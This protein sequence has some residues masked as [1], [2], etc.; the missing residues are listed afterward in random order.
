MKRPS[1]YAVSPASSNPARQLTTPSADERSLGYHT[2]A[3]LRSA[4]RCEPTLKTVL[5]ID[6]AP[7]KDKKCAKA[8]KARVS[9]SPF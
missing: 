9:K 6:K 3:F 5:G 8:N 4:M 2:G 1:R 7:Q